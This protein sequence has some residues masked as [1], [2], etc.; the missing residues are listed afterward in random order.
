MS[1]KIIFI[2]LLLSTAAMAEENLP[3]LPTSPTQWKATAVAD[4][5][6]AYIETLEN[7]PGV[8]DSSNP[9]FKQ[10]L[11][12]AKKI[13]LQM[14]SQVKNVS[15][16]AATIARFSNVIH[17]GHAGAFFTIDDSHMPISRWPGFITAWR[18]DSL[19][20]YSSQHQEIPP[21]AKVVSCDRVPIKE[22]IL[23]NV[24]AFNGLSEQ[25]GQWWSRSGKVFVDEYGNPFIKL[26][27]N[28]VFEVDCKH[29]AQKL[30]WQAIPTDFWQAYR[31]SY[32][33]EV[34]PVGL[35]EPRP[36]LF[37]VAMPTFTPD[38]AQQSAYFEM[39]K[40]IQVNREKFMLAD[41]VVIDLRHNQGGSSSW[42]RYFAEALWGK[43]IVEKRMESY[44]AGQ[45]VWWRASPDNTAYVAQLVDQVR[46]E[47]QQDTADEFKA[48]A[49][50]MQVALSRS[51]T[52]Y[53]ERDEPIA[54]NK[55]QGKPE[56]G[57]DIASFNKRV[58]VIVPGQCAS[59]CLDALDVFTQFPNTIL[60][61]APSAADSTYLDIRVKALP[62]GLGKV[63]IPNKMYVHRPR[64]AGQVYKPS[65]LIADLD[66]STNNLLTVV[67]RDMVKSEP[68]L[69]KLK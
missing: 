18:G 66:W 58:Y 37:W 20:V 53:V 36:G 9:K 48:V 32:E 68:S 49:D 19:F 23:K 61:G 43:Q 13:A 31:R 5:N 56:Q 7:H 52:F 15:G 21:G 33:A 24:F 1:G 59:A 57:S 27:T 38:Q 30:H 45:E 51:E 44:T 67:E 29:I 10:Q 25:A 28:C 17:D 46:A 62:S 11:D 34:L 69:E 35:T 65:I 64:A 22:L 16:Y 12:S 40:N 26:P 55:E 50:G 39:I 6:A 63:I 42:S 4:V 3:T 47:N 8:A 14:A 2:C 41:A 54:D 60:I